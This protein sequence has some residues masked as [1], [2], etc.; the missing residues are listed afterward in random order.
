MSEPW[1]FAIVCMQSSDDYFLSSSH[2]L[3]AHF[4]IVNINFLASVES[5]VI[6]R[7]LTQECFVCVQPKSVL[8]N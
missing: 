8:K 7:N 4:A 2:D 5:A 1:S 3:V 6:G